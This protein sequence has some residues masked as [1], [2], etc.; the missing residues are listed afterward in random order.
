MV[1]LI[2]ILN[3]EWPLGKALGNKVFSLIMMERLKPVFNLLHLV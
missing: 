1:S 3:S 2:I